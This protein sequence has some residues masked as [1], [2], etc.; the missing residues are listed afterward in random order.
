M[1]TNEKNK[2]EVIKMLVEQSK[3]LLKTVCYELENVILDKY[4]LKRKISDLYY[5][6][7]WLTEALL[8]S[9]DIK[10]IKRHTTLIYEFNQNFDFYNPIGKL[11]NKRQKADYRIYAFFDEE[12]V[13]QLLKEVKEFYKKVLEYLKEKK[14]L[15]E[16]EIEELK[17]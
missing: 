2:K 10:D 17:I 6:V 9:K 12:E 8:L 14:I 4:S 3:S 16:K 15:T 7:F 11:F 5:I 1:K 13:E